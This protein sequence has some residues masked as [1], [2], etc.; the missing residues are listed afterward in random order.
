MSGRNAEVT[1]PDGSSSAPILSFSE[2][3][4]TDSVPVSRHEKIIAVALLAAAFLWRLFYAFRA[5]IDSDEPQHLHIAW[6]QAH[7]LL[8]YRDVFNHHPPLFYMLCSPLVRWMGDR[9]DLVILMRL[10]M[11]PLLCV[12]LW[13]VYRIA[14]SLFSRRMALWAMVCAAS[15]PFG[16]KA[17]VE[18]RTDNLWTMFWM[19][20]MAVLLCGEVTPWR[21]LVAGLIMGAAGGVTQKTAVLMACLGIGYVIVVTARSGVADWGRIARRHTVSLAAGVLGFAVI[22]S[23]LAAWFYWKGAFAEFYY[24]IVQHNNVPGTHGL[25]FFLKVTAFVL[26]ALLLFLVLRRRMKQSP[27]DP[28]A[29]KRVFLF[30]FV[31][32]YYVAAMTLIPFL[33]RTHFLPIIPIIAIG[34]VRFA[35]PALAWCSAFFRSGRLAC[36]AHRPH[37]AAI[38]LI[39]VQLAYL[40]ARAPW[41]DETKPYMAQWKAVLQLIKPTDYVMD[42]KGELLFG[43]RAFYYTLEPEFGLRRIELGLIKDTIPENL[44]ET[45][46]CVVSPSIRRMPARGRHFIETNYVRA[47][48]LLVAG[49]FLR[50]SSA[51]TTQPVAFDIRIPAS[52]CVVTANGSASGWLDRLPYDGPRFLGAGRHEFRP[53]SAQGTPALVW[54]RAIQRGFSPAWAKDKPHGR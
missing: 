47:G 43:R 35:R 41:R 38:V 49:Q 13:C 50:P 14:K 19:L 18:S 23:A 22:P 48:P 12:T 32:L 45:R 25:D 37:V 51:D 3:G 16:F 2:G 9:P 52:Y 26:T 7:G 28:L 42:R 29:F 30:A 24:G 36:P 39:V 8:Q 1:L 31:A 44:V 21:S 54:S 17:T 33:D 40:A 27:P 5:Y 4:E 20:A 34:A 46:C 6:A 11:L 15:L 10:A 53:K